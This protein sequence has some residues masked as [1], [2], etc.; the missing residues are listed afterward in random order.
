MDQKNDKI[1]GSVK[2]KLL[3]IMQVKYDD[4]GKPSKYICDAD[5]DA[6]K[7]CD[8]YQDNLN[9]GNFKRHVI[10]HHRIV[11]ERLDLLD[12][13][14]SLEPLEHTLEE[15][16]P[17]AKRSRFN[18]LSVETNRNQILLGTM[19]LATC[20]NLPLSY[21]EW[22]GM[23]HLCGPQW[24]AAGMDMSRFTLTN[25]T[26]QGATLGKERIK[27]EMTGKVVHLKIDLA[28]RGGRHAFGINA[29]FMGDD[30]TIQIRT[31]G[32]FIMICK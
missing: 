5:P 4:S 32:K 16:E 7:K 22:K 25:M 10:S 2:R 19:E 28:S 27:R 29:Q 3:N 21:P 18:K 30:D 13:S 26:T 24:K 31:L 9:T 23:Q 8:Y 15:G 17:E 14:T 11:A 12:L 6:E 20:H 1:R